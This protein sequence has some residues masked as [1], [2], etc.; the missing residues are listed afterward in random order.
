MNKVITYIDG[1]NLYHSIADLIRRNTSLKHLQWQNPISL[2][3]QFLPNN[4]IMKS[5]YFF[6]AYPYWKP[7]FMQEHKDYIEILEDLGIKIVLGNFKEKKVYCHNCHTTI[8]KHE[9]KQTDVNIA[10][11]ILRDCYE[12]RCDCMQIISADTDLTTPIKFAKDKGIKINIVLP[13][14]RK[15][16]ELI[17]LADKK[18]NIKAKHL[19]NAYLGQSYKLKNGKILQN[20]HI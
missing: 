1:F 18:S 4:D 9:E 11:Q 19:Q 3:K 17:A 13:P 8:T 15:A 12:K 2:S 14:Y 6:S 10:M 7:H 5:I 16:K 20:P